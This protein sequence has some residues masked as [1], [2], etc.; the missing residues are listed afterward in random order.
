LT[1]S[2]INALP[3]F[4]GAHLIILNFIYHTIVGEQYRSLSLSLCS[5]TSN[6][7]ATNRHNMHAIYQLDVTIYSYILETQ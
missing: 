2:G 6:L 7:A 5:S 1:C 3:S 4:P